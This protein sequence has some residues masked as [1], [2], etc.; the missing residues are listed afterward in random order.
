MSE[1]VLYD[2]WRSSASY[3]VRIALNLCGI[4][5]RSQQVDLVKGDQR[6]R[7]HLER[8]AQ[9][10]VPVLELDGH[11]FTQSIAIIEYLQETRGYPFLPEAAVER[12]RM[13]A[14]AF[15]IA[16]ETHPVCNT[17][18]A[19]D[20]VEVSGREGAD[21]EAVRSGWMQR[22]IRRGLLA[23]D[24]LLGEAAGPCC[25]GGTPGMADLCLVPQF[26]NARRWGADLEGLSR[27]AR[28]ADHC[29]Q[30]PAFAA[31]HPDRFRPAG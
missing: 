15:V 5:F 26:Y 14:L 1:A 30:L 7:E 23:F 22:H 10:L 13:R 21:A 4:A 6:S 11:R 2:Y 17:S 20:V 31:A 18:I 8:N 9:G 28:I 29:A 12:A 3:R 24:A 19:A 27:L 25:H 16:M